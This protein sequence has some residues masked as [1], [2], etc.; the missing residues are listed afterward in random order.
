MA[1]A[2]EAGIGVVNRLLFAEGITR[3][4]D[5]ITMVA[6]PLTAVLV[7]GS[8]PGELALIGA[9]Q[10][11]PIL[12]L[13]IPAGTWVDRRARRWPILVVADLVRAALLAAVPLAAIAGVLSVPLLAAVAFAASVCGTLF[14]L[15]FAGWVPRLLSG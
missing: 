9:A 7:L 1:A 8:S 2:P 13:S 11:L 3:L 12:L 4:G 14:D 15:S 5:A 10:A 6:L